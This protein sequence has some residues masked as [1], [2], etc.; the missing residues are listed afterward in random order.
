[1]S[2]GFAIQPPHSAPRLSWNASPRFQVCTKQPESKARRPDHPVAK[3]TARGDWA[4]GLAIASSPALLEEAVQELKQDIHANSSKRP[5]AVKLGT[6][7][8]FAC[9][10]GFANHDRVTPGHTGGSL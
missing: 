2:E 1:M 5:I 4:K 3:P 7:D 6:W 8:L 9:R 10:A